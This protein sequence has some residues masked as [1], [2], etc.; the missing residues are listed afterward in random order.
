[1]DCAGR[2]PER[3]DAAFTLFDGIDCLL[4]NAEL[5]AHLHAVAAN[6]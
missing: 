4:T 5:V 1:V 6:L 3:V 2:L